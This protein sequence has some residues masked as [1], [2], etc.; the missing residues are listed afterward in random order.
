MV[1]MRRDRQ[2]LSEEDITIVLRVG[3]SGVLS[4]LGEDGYP[5]GVPLSYVYDEINRRIYLHGGK[6]GHKLDAIRYYDKASFT[7][8]N[9]DDPV[10]NMFDTMYR[11][12]IAFGKIR[13]I[14]DES[15]IRHSLMLLGEKFTEPDNPVVGA[16]IERKWNL[17]TT[18]ALDIEHMTGKESIELVVEKAE[19]ADN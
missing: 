3:T 4:L 7:V 6:R 5:Y 15:E 17:V 14:A 1:P 18:I 8:I 19:R 2:L 9:R 10:P 16:Y 11:S 12:V 13:I